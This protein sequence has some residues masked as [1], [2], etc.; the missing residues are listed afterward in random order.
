[1]M[2]RA[3]FALGIVAAALT[4]PALTSS[5]LAAKQRCTVYRDSS[6]TCCEG[7]SAAM[8]SA[9]YDVTIIDIDHGVR[10][11]RFQIPLELASC[12]TAVIGPYLVEGHVPM[13]AVARLLHRRTKTR[14]IALPGMPTG[15][16][17]M[18]GPKSPIAVVLLDDPKHVFYS[19]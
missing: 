7:W 14:G 2:K 15:V 16:P 4:A 18:P 13:P 19:E 6:C 12:H 3:S 1:M 10:L 5:A 9:G 8:R 11:A 17:G